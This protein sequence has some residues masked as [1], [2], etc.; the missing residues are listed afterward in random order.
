MCSAY[1]RTLV[2]CCSLSD[3]VV[4]DNDA[5]EKLVIHELKVKPADTVYDFFCVNGPHTFTDV[6]NKIHLIEGVFQRQMFEGRSFES[7]E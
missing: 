5:L 6:Q 3:D 1:G 4:A 7:L 2:I